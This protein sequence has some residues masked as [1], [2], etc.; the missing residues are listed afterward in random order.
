[1][2]GNAFVKFA[3]RHTEFRGV[4]VRICS[5][6]WH[7]YTD[8]NYELKASGIWKTRK[9]RADYHLREVI[10][11]WVQKGD[12]TFLEIGS[13]DF[14]FLSKLKAMFPDLSLYAYDKYPIG[15]PPENIQFISD[16]KQ[17]ER[18]DYVYAS[19]AL[20]HIY[21]LDAFFE[22]L[23]ERLT[24]GSV[25]II[26]VPNN[27]VEKHLE[28]KRRRHITGYHFHFFNESSL[29]EIFTRHGFDTMSVY[30]YGP[31]R[32]ELSAINLVG[33]FRRI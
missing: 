29:R 1:M 33:V 22:V 24:P 30:A 5:K 9:E 14:Y 27:S 23:K 2:C 3:Y 32:W 6:C 18:V 25:L 15:E 26:E 17:V 13:C 10:P 11:K 20:E 31:K 8:R 4:K 16:L 28:V 19:H 12:G 21:D 7:G